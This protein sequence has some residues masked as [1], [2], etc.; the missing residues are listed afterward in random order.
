MKIAEVIGYM[1]SLWPITYL[2]VPFGD[3][4]NCKLLWDGVVNKVSSRYK[5]GKGFSFQ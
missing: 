2:S 1:T 3:N 5:I 4:F